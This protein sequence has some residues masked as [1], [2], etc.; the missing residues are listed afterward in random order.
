MTFTVY[1]TKRCSVCGKGGVI[2]VDEN[3]L[4]EWLRGSNIQEAFPEM[5]VELREQMI[6]GIH[7]VCWNSI[8]VGISEE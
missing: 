8:F 1:S 6:S 3:K 7:P 2:S 5:P 4:F